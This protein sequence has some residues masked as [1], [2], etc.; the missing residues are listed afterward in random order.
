MYL[1]AGIP[2]IGL[3]SVKYATG[4]YP[5]IATPSGVTLTGDMSELFAQEKKAYEMIIAIKKRFVLLLKST[6][7]P[8]LVQN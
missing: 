5:L 2:L 3:L 8:S 7:M 6:V 4:S 1:N